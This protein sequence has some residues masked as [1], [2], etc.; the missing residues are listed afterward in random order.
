MSSSQVSRCKFTEGCFIPYDSC[1]FHLCSLVIM[2][3]RT[4]YVARKL[5]FLFGCFTYSTPLILNML[6]TELLSDMLICGSLVEGG[7]HCWGGSQHTWAASRFPPAPASTASSLQT[8]VPPLLTPHL[9]ILLPAIAAGEHSGNKTLES[10]FG[11]CF[12][13]FVFVLNCSFGRLNRCMSS[14]EGTGQTE[15][16]CF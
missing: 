8:H 16:I 13:G 3:R 11:F 1:R 6:V 12:F 2:H 5:L 9:L 7:G 10:R 15:I 4:V 14:E